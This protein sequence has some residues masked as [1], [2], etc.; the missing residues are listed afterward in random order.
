[1]GLFVA[2]VALLFSLPPLTESQSM[3]LAQTVDGPVMETA[4]FY[5]LLENAVAGGDDSDASNDSDATMPRKP[6]FA[7]LYGRGDE[8]RGE[9]FALSG[10]LQQVTTVSVAR[11]GEW[12]EQVTRWAVLV[13]QDPDEVVL[14]ILPDADDAYAAW[15]P[16]ARVEVTMVGRLFQV[17]TA[18]RLDGTGDDAFLMF[19]AAEAEAAS[20]TMNAAAAPR[21]LPLGAVIGLTVAL[22]GVLMF[23]VRMRG[24]AKA[25]AGAN[26]AQRQRI[27]RP[28]DE[29][30]GADVGEDESLP[31]D[32]AEALEALGRDRDS[33]TKSQ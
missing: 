4:G 29:V 23:V 15:K 8:L 5:A 9:A 14:V 13:A 22:A 16:G 20:A 28:D 33:M 10:L 3:R 25:N 2:I 17:F 6:A 19:V 12:G 31:E 26:A 1:M 11:H 7:A 21:G 30:G 27:R 32:P 18:P 24:A